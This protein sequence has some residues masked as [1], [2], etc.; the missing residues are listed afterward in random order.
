MLYLEMS[1]FKFRKATIH[2]LCAMLEKKFE[3]ETIDVFLGG[4]AIFY[5]T[6]DIQ[7]LKF[8]FTRGNDVERVR[9]Y[10]RKYDAKQ[11]L[12]EYVEEYPSTYK[13]FPA[14]RSDKESLSNASKY[15]IVPPKG[16]NSSESKKFIVLHN[17][18]NEKEKLVPH[19]Y[20]HSI[21]SVNGY[22]T[23]YFNVEYVFSYSDSEDKIL[24]NYSSEDF[25]EAGQET[26]KKISNILYKKFKHKVHEDDSQGN[27][28]LDRKGNVVWLDTTSLYDFIR[29]L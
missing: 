23:S 9:L 1:P 12:L 29:F 7:G 13:K 5:R 26:H 3:N 27:Y 8:I 11:I 4:E 19:I 24:Q 28:G 15:T 21:A 18:L 16:M 22:N 6:S 10:N 2:G 17:I 14:L 25:L 20:G